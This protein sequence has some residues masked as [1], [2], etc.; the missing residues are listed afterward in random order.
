MADENVV[1]S[2]KSKEE[3]AYQLSKDLLFSASDSRRE[4]TKKQILDHYL[5]AR[6]VVYGSGRYDLPS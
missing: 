3:I 5:A 1:A 6:A 2:G 4:P